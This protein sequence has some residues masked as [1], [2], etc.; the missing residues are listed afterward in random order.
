M[1]CGAGL[2]GFSNGPHSAG[3][4]VVRVGSDRAHFRLRRSHCG[5][6]CALAV[7]GFH[8]LAH[9]DQSLQLVD[10]HGR[11]ARGSLD[12][13]NDGRAIRVQQGLHGEDLV[14]EELDLGLAILGDGEVGQ[15]SLVLA[16]R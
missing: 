15:V 3:L 5:V 4:R 12:H 10:I 11:I 16:S 1:R 13:V 14:G 2:V 8:S 7:G 9:F 6:E